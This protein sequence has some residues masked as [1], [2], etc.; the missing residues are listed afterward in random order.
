LQTVAYGRASGDPGLWDALFLEKAT[1]EYSP[2]VRMPTCL[3]AHQHT[4]QSFKNTF[5][6][7]YLDQDMLKM[8]YFLEKARKVAACWGLRF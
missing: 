6:S 3:G 1:E 2:R 4:L 7:R 5:L 8:L